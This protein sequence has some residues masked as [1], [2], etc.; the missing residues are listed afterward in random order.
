MS[1]LIVKNGQLI[2]GTG[3]API[4]E[5]LVHI[6]NER[7]VYAGGASGYEVPGGAR[8]VDAEG[9][10]ILP[11]L[12]DTHVHLAMTPTADRLRHQI[13]TPFSYLFYE[14][15]KNFNDTLMAGITTV[16]DAAGIDFGTKKACED[17]LF[18]GPRVMISVSMLSVTGGHGDDWQR[19][20][21]NPGIDD[22]PGKPGG[23]CDGVESTRRVVREVLRAGAEMIKISSTGGVLSPT[24]RCEYT[25]FSPEELK[26]IV[27]EAAFH[28]GKKV[29]THAQGTEGI[30]F[31]VKAGVHS[32]EHGFFLDDEII[33]IMVEKNIFLV[34]TFLAMRTVIER[35]KEFGLPEF[36]VDKAKQADARHQESVRKAREAGVKVAMGTD[37]GVMEHGTNL[38][39]LALLVENGMT[40]MEAI[41]ATTKT[42]AECLTWQDRLGTLES[43]KLADVTISKVNPLKQIGAL[44]D[45][46]QISIV[47]QNGKV[48]KG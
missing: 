8:V 26:V 1:A 46:D 7:I 19:S 43:G 34:P 39:E 35:G 4:A 29:F 36:M 21:V 11:G 24:D 45:N 30:K 22:Y 40:P 17:G 18:P 38:R 37:A 6:E 9:G 16:R 12:I 44:A 48:V 33:E 47:I 32:V 3:A 20:G 31:A 2:D 10:T 28:G 15:M 5:G 27:E 41:V 13:S 14:R 23:L 42:A 25:Q